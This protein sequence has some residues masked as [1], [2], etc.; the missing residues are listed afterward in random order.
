[1]TKFY[2]VFWIINYY[3]SFIHFTRKILGRSNNFFVQNV[4]KLCLQNQSKIKIRFSFKNL[5]LA[6][7]LNSKMVDS[8]NFVH[9]VIFIIY[10]VSV[11]SF[12]LKRS[13]N[14]GHSAK[15]ERALSLQLNFDFL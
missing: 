10:E 12:P 13:L 7:I 1:M 9:M 6:F 5:K 4:L 2:F 3:N 8:S 11:Y 14:G 15:F